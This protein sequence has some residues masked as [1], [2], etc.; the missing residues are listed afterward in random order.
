M[1]D[2][3]TNAGIPE[4]TLVSLHFFASILQKAPDGQMLGQIAG[5]RLFESFAEWPCF[6]NH[7]LPDFDS[8]NAIK[9]LCED[10][11]SHAQNIGS[12]QRELAEDHLRLFSGPNPAAPPWESVW[13]EKDGL[14]FGEQT[15]KVRNFYLDFGLG[16]ANA[17]REPE[18]HLGLEIAFVAWL[19]GTEQKSLSGRDPSRALAAFMNDHLLCWQE[20]C[21]ARAAQNAASEFYRQNCLLC[22]LALKNV[23][24]AG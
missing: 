21:L 22:S 19:G 15:E 9:R 1:R 4:T 13:R 14:L 3:S 18:D 5:E 8:A 6:D 7:C 2:F 12:W 24:P 20:A 17:G 11:K 23:L 10:A 16:S